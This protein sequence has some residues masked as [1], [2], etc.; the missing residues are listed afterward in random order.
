MSVI[1][2]PEAAAQ[3]QYKNGNAHPNGAEHRTEALLELLLARVEAM[4]QRLQRYE[5]LVAQAPAFVGMATDTVDGWMSSLSQRGI[6]VDARARDLLA[7]LERLSAPETVAA[8]RTLID[9][10]P[11]VSQLAQ[12]APGMVAMM[13]DTLDEAIARMRE[14]GVDIEFLVGAG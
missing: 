9:L 12:Q 3:P 4:N 11:T 14:N 7:L 1:P 6:D 10:L 5:A 2:A 13:V 8:L